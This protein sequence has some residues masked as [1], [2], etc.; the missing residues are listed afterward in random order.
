MTDAQDKNELDETLREF[1]RCAIALC[2]VLDE[3][4]P[5]NDME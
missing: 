2:N 5:L 4:K 1:G 3:D